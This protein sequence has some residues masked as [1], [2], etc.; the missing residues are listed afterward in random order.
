MDT[1]SIYIYAD[2]DQHGGTY[3]FAIHSLFLGIL[4]SSFDLHPYFAERDL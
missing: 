4:I 1:N 3:I 2:E